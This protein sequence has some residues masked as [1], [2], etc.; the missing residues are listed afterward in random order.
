M[1]IE[2]IGLEKS[3]H[4]RKVVNGVNLHVN[5]GEVVGLLGPNGAG[6]TTS[7]YMIVGLVRPDGGKIMMGGADISKFPMHKRAR[8]GI[9]Y[10]PQESSI[11]RKLSV[12]DN[13]MA[14]LEFMDLSL[15]EREERL[16]TLLAELNVA[17]L[18][19][20][21]AYTLSGGERRRVEVARALATKPE[22]ILLDEPFAGID[23]IA[24]IEIQKII[25][26]LKSRGIG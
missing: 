3:Y 8:L 22:Y 10:L 7:F 20:S 24:V 14:V 12:R 11:F 16:Q 25:A 9:S 26:Q 23:P 18:T 4:K 2:A 5:P 15:A 19:Q 17:H 13:I 21:K 6:K 1:S